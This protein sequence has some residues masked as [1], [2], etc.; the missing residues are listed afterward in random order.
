MKCEYCNSEHD[1]K[2][3]S[4][5]F[6]NQRCARGYASRDKREEINKKVSKTLKNLY[7]NSENSS[8][9]R[10]KSRQCA[11]RRKK[12]GTNK[13]I[14]EVS[15]KLKKYHERKRIEKWQEW[16]EKGEFPK[17]KNLGHI[18][19]YLENKNGHKCE[20]CNLSEWQGK[21]I[22]LVVDHID[23]NNDNF[24]MNNFRLICNNCDSIS[25]T[26]KGKNRGKGRKAR[27]G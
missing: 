23:G 14:A 15:I 21:T 2:Y 3:G 16:G 6:C 1:G 26:F 5:R 12:W 8:A 19:E 11:S 24:K 27:S 25:P 7:W 10:E 17:L 20:Q 13:K 4:G 9:L 22:P 18:R